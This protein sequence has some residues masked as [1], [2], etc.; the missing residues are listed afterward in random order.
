MDK[1]QEWLDSLQVGDEVAM[2][3]GSYGYRK[4]VK[5]TITKITPKRRLSASNGKTFNPD[6]SEYGKGSSWSKPAD[7]LP[8]TQDIAEH[9]E[10]NTLLNLIENTKF[11]KCSLEQLRSIQAI[12]KG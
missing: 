6:G 8:M 5:A 3:V 2:D 7:L 12:L 1:K 11:D 9:I 4:Y 10:R